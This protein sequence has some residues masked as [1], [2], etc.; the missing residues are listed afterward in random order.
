MPQIFRTE[1]AGRESFA[2]WRE[3]VCDVFVQ[4]DCSRI[5]DDEFSGHLAYRRA[6]PLEITEVDAVPQHVVRSR[7][8]IAKGR[9]DD[10]LV[11]VQLAGDG[12]VRQ[13]GREAHLEPGD[14][15]LYD[16]T[17][18]YVLHFDQPFS[19]LV[20][21]MPRTVLLDRLPV[22]DLPTATR[23]A[24]SGGVGALVSSF[25]RSFGASVDQMPAP[26]AERLAANAVDMLAVGI[27][28]ATDGRSDGIGAPAR[29]TAVLVAVK[30]FIE[31]N[32]RRYDL[33]VD[34]VAA[35]HRLSPRYLRRLFAAEGTS[36]GRWIWERRFERARADLADPLLAGRS[37]TDLALGWGFNDM[38]HF[39]RGF[40]AR[41]GLSP[42]AYRVTAL[43]GGRSP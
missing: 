3:L 21:Q 43:S 35:A 15:A 18:P 19:Q 17:R 23:V 4:L 20:L 8:Q 26:A 38:S 36:P 24:G 37:V 5:T 16:S 22:P 6:G 11:S 29:R 12:I 39:S 31:A 25:L 34:M 9:E 40:R 41:Y 13:D 7:A 32:L 2:Y 14:F 1:D 33:D 30:R 27:W 10:C 28:A 42:R